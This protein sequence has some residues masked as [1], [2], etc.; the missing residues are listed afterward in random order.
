MKTRIISLAI[1]VLLT[2]TFSTT[3]VFPDDKKIIYTTLDVKQDYDIV[4]F[5]HGFA[6]VG[7][8]VFGDP[9]EGAY[10]DVWKDFEDNAKKLDADAVVGIRMEFQNLTEKMVGRLIL[11]GTAVRFRTK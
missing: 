4:G 6:Q 5:V 8:R 3:R 7:S 9:F 1:V 2:T 10:E 11:Y